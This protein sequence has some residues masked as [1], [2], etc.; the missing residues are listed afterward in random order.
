MFLEVGKLSEACKQ[1][2]LACVAVVSVSFK[3][4]GASTKDAQGERKR[5]LRRL[6]VR[7]QWNHS[8][9]LRK[10]SDDTRHC[11][12][13]EKTPVDTIQNRKDMCEK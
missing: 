5:L 1:C 13:N 8:K 6:S 11:S 10:S 7:K 9:G 3:P 4:S 12:A 2:S